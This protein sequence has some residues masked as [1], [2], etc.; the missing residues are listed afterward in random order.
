MHEKEKCSEVM[1]M[2]LTRMELDMKRRKT[3]LA[4]TNRKLFHGAVES[5]F[6][7]ER[8]RRLWRIDRFGNIYYLLIV[9]EDK[10]DLKSA[11]EQFGP[12]QKEAY[13]ETKR[14]DAL[15]D[16]IE[17]GSVWQFRLTANPTVSSV[18]NKEGNHLEK[19]RE[20]LKRGT[21]Y[22]HNVD[23]YQREWLKK[24]AERNGFHIEDKNFSVVQSQWMQFFKGKE[25]SR[26]SF[27]GVTYEGVLTV[28]DCEAF[29]KALTEG[30]GREKAYG[31]GMLTVVKV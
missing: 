11:F 30:I 31:M 15:L 16:R 28:T 12:Y 24:K 22:A 4:L 27:L 26:V 9:S 10:P 14:Y 8:K 23:A 6:E 20:K 21:V 17:N 13:W 1:E 18:K 2:Y 5:A 29:V 19:E 3:M 25:G 7:G